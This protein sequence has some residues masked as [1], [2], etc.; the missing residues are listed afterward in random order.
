MAF[1]YKPEEVYAMNYETLMERAVLAEYKLM[2]MGMISDPIGIQVPEGE[3]K[4]AP[5]HRPR[6]DAKA[7]W[8]AQNAPKKKKK[9]WKVSPVLE[10]EDR[11]SI[12]FEEDRLAA[13]SSIL[14]NHD[15][16]EHPMVQEHIM[17]ERLGPEREKLVNDAQ[18]IY[19]DLI[20][21]LNKKNR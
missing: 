21:E 16:A 10:A 1:P 18:W 2:E 14:D 20:K 12:N 4:P 11:K 3:G 8:D 13:D 17:N 15:R 5:P 6:V 19:G 7:M 9:K